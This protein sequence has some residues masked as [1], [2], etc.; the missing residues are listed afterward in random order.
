MLEILIIYNL[1]K[2]EI[3]KPKIDN[4]RI[5]EILNLI[6][7]NQINVIYFKNSIRKYCR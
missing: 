1:L 5:S 3:V 4:K 2:Q 7:E 6:K